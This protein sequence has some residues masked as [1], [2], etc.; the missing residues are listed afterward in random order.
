MFIIRLLRFLLGYVKFEATG[1]F[2]ERFINLCSYNG[3]KIWGIIKNQEKICAYI[4]ARDYKKLRRIA[5]KTLMHPRVTRRYGLPFI[6]RKFRARSGLFAGAA[7]AAVLIYTLSLSVWNI[8]IE[9]NNRVETAEIQAVLKSLGMTEGVRRDEVDTEKIR[10]ELLLSMP[11]LSWAAVNLN[12]T[13]AVIE[14]SE[15]EPTDTNK[16]ITPCN[17]VAKSDG[18]IVSVDVYKGLSNIKEGDAVVKGDLLISGVVDH[19]NGTASFLHASGSVIAETESEISVR[20]DYNQ[21]KKVRTGKV[22][23]KRVLTFL[24]I[25]I[26]LYLGSEKDEYE[27]E[28]SS[29]TMNIGGVNM[30]VK[31]NTGNFYFVENVGV[32]LTEDEALNQARQQIE[33]IEK[34]RYQSA[35][36]LERQE[37]VQY[38]EKGLILTVKYLCRENIGVEE[39][40]LINDTE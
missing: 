14:V 24:G 3:I 26:P 34:S 18:R 7:V 20:V 39:S 17:I 6:L 16:D 13:S 35:E 10:H 32:T 8:Q 15:A 28:L 36:I 5:K 30:P 38:D 9:G 37:F 2:C 21:V 12:G 25:E 27:L 23:T 40:I 11:E 22:K 31:I 4:L 19:L 33:E 29:W 1:V